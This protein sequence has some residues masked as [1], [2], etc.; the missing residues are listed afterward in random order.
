MSSTGFSLVGL[1]KVKAH[2]SN[3]FFG[4][5]LLPYLFGIEAASVKQFSQSEE[6]EEL[7]I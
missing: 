6:S 1:A 4:P 2:M 3:C 7:L 5:R